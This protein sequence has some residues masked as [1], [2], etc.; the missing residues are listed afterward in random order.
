[1]SPAGRVVIILSMFLGRVGPITLFASVL[2]GRAAST[3]YSYPH[4]RVLLN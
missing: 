3:R 4:E 1:L 2:V